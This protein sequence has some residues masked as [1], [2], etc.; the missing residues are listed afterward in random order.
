MLRPPCFHL[1]QGLH[2]LKLATRCFWVAT[3]CKDKDDGKGNQD[4]QS[5]LKG[6]DSSP[7]KRIHGNKGRIKLD[8]LVGALE[9]SPST[10]KSGSLLSNLM[11]KVDDAE[12]MKKQFEGKISET[13]G[14]QRYD[15]QDGPTL[16]L[17]PDF[18]EYDDAPSDRKPTLHEQQLLQESSEDFITEPQNSFE[19]MMM[20][21]DKEWNFPIDNQQDLGI[22]DQ[23]GFEDHVFLEHYLDDFPNSEPIQKYMELVITGLQQNPYLS[24]AQKQERIM[25]YKSYF[26]KFPEDELQVGI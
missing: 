19:V 1:Q 16:S 24:V 5:L 25:F 14:F 23:T 4:L 15:L 21:S 18:D 10:R 12:I 7:P 26:T 6:L 3:L 13:D 11:S 9:S 22:E 2:Q 8:E 17:F 20:N